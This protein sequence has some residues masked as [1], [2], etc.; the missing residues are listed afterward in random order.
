MIV[1]AQRAGLPIILKEH[2]GF[3][4]FTI[5]PGLEKHILSLLRKES[6]VEAVKRLK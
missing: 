4:D 2:D 1:Q 6:G 5:G 3:V